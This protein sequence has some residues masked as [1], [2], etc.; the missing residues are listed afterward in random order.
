MWAR[1]VTTLILFAL[2]CASSAYWVMQL[3]APVPVVAAAASAIPAPPNLD[4]ALHARLFGG[5]VR[6]SSNI[7]VTGVVAPTQAHAP[8]IALLGIDDQPARAYS[9]GQTLAGGTILREVHVDRVV[10]DQGGAL[11][12]LSVPQARP[13]AAS[14][15]G[16]TPPGQ[17]APQPNT[18]VNPPAR[19]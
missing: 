3:R 15:Q 14:S 2:L 4:T 19:R 5:A 13:G 6:G 16:V 17:P 8:G 7:R 11:S 10:I 12:E 1:R 9:T 18:G